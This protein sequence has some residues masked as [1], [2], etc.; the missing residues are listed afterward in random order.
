MLLG[1]GIKPEVGLMRGVGF[2]CH[3]DLSAG[4]CPA[5]RESFWVWQASTY[6]LFVPQSLKA[7]LQHMLH[8]LVAIDLGVK[9]CWKCRSNVACTHALPQFCRLVL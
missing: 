4:G 7:L 8:D 5:G 9:M 1:L 2:L 3:Y 6:D